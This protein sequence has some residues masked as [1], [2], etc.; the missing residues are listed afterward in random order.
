MLFLVHVIS[1]QF[2]MPIYVLALAFPVHFR[3]F[4]LYVNVHGIVDFRYIFHSNQKKECQVPIR[5][6]LA[7]S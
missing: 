1:I 5:A 6:S 4:S 3:S 2:L 7:L